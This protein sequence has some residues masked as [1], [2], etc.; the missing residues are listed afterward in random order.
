M[1][2]PLLVVLLSL[3]KG[4]GETWAH[5]TRYF[6]LRYLGNSLVLVGGVGILST[7]LGVS[8]A[9]AV[10]RYAFP[11]RELVVKLLYLPCLLSPSG[12]ADEYASCHSAR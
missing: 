11:G 2:I 12:A 10:S 6:L 5:L 9:W 3:A 8:A 1:A 4:T 7:I